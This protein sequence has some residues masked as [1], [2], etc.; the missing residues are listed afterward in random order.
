MFRSVRRPSS[1]G[2]FPCLVQLLLVNFSASSHSSYVAVCFLYVCACAVLVGVVSGCVLCIVL[3][4]NC[5][6]VL[7]VCMSW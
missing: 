4:E 3:N 6:S 2:W 1:G 7:I 5:E